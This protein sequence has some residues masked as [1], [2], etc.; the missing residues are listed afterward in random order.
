MTGRFKAQDLGFKVQVFELAV[1]GHH[2]VGAVVEAAKGQRKPFRI[3]DLELRI[4]N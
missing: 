1:V 4:Q 2:V 3:Y